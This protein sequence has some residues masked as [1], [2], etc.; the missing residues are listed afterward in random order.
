[1]GYHGSTIASVSLSGKPDMHAD[2]NLPLDGFLHTDWPHFYRHS[3]PGESET[4]YSSR[5]AQRLE[6]LIISEGPET[7]AAFFAEPVMGAAGGVVPPDGYFEKVQSVLR[8][9]DILFVVDEVVCG[10]GRTGRMWGSETYNIQPD[11]LTTAKALSAAALPIS[12]V[13]VNDKVYQAMLDESDKLGSFAHGFTYAGHPVSAAVAVETLKIY[14]EIDVVKLAQKNGEMLSQALMPAKDHPLVGDISQ[15]GL[16]AGIELVCD[17]ATRKLFGPEVGIGA[18]VVA[19][20][21][22]HGL[23]HRGMGDRV[24]FAPP[25]IIKET[26]IQNI[27][28]RFIQALDDVW[29]ETRSH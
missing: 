5:L 12:A 14:E 18:R 2:F 29:A 22:R 11:I 3:E 24:A 23:I 1:M 28:N 27:G 17:K 15:V 6:S 16:L 7:I 9:Y 4:E 19:A 8:K 21:Q 25:F 20:S 10:Y 13:M 26:E